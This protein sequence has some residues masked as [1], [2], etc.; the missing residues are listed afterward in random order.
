MFLLHIISMSWFPTDPER[1]LDVEKNLLI[2]SHRIGLSID[3]HIFQMEF[4]R[5]IWRCVLF[6]FIRR[7]D[8][9]WNICQIISHVNLF[10]YN[11]LS[12]NAYQKNSQNI[13]T[14]KLW[15]LIVF[16]FIYIEISIKIHCD[17][18]RIV[19]RSN[20]LLCVD[21][22]KSVNSMFPLILFH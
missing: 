17:L 20:G 1:I 15:S 3:R 7:I 18:N 14:I 4:M 22:S 12:V 11:W 2:A 16:I 19:V 9:K 10:F 21:F 5:F 8:K 13:K 6:Q